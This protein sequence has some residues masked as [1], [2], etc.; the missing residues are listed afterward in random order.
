M[1]PDPLV[2]TPDLGGDPPGTS[3]RHACCPVFGLTTFV[4]WS[5]ISTDQESTGL[6]AVPCVAFVK[7][8]LGPCGLGLAAPD[9]PA[10]D[11]FQCDVS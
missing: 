1:E 3:V 8:D 11:G 9:G 5:Q 2:R 4:Q 6:G 7:L 10:H